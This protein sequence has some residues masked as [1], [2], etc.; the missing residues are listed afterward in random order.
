MLENLVESEIRSRISRQGKI[1][2]AEFMRLALY[3]PKFGYYTTPSPFG[4]EGD[5]F[6]SPAAHPTFGALLAFQLQRMWELLGNPPRFFVIEMGVGNGLLARDI[7][8]YLAQMTG[9]FPQALCY[10]ALERYALGDATSEPEAVQRIIADSIPG[11]NVVGCFISNELVD[12]FPVHRFQ[13]HKGVLKEIFVTLDDRDELSEVLGEP[14][15]PDLSARI[16]ELETSLPEGFRGEINFD[17]RPW[18]RNVSDAL[19][20]GFVITIDYGHMEQD[21]YS[22]DRARGTIQTYYNHTQGSSPYQRIGRQDITAHVDF[23]LI[24]SEGESAGLRPV[25]LLSQSEFLKS[26]GFHRMLRQVRKNDLSPRERSANV[27]GMLELVK[28]DGLGGFKVLIQERGT[29]IREVNQLLPTE[30]PKEEADV[31]LLRTAHAPLMEGRY[32]HLSWELN[33]LRPPM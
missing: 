4:S 6:T 32:P 10:V 18:M 21:L 25:A 27:M 5:Y 8:N 24:M 7:I 2:F 17:I 26:L 22:P 9:S 3:Y 33:D 13:V 29:G 15:T 28:P 23:S 11:E 31:P 30:M 14:S 12:S 1:T 16:N 20:Q 19:Q